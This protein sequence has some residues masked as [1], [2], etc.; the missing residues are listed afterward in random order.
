MEV[1]LKIISSLFHLLF[2]PQIIRGKNQCKNGDELIEKL[3][4]R[5]ANVASLRDNV[6]FFLIKDPYPPSQDEFIQDPLNWP[7]VS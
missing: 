4:Q 5:I 7:Q 1:R 3:D 6:S 2:L